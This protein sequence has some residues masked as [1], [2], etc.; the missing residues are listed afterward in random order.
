VRRFF[1]RSHLG[2]I[3]RGWRYP[4]R[5]ERSVLPLEALDLGNVSRVASAQTPSARP[6]AMRVDPVRPAVG[7]IG[8]RSLEVKVVDECSMCK[9]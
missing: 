7:S 9:G 6:M 1:G 8:D 5:A 2:I 3:S 4:L